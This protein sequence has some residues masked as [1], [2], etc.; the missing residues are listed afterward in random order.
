VGRSL[1][2][3][4]S[5]IPAAIGESAPASVVD[6]STA[7]RTGIEP[8]LS[9]SVA[10]TEAD[11]ARRGARPPVPVS[12]PI[13]D[14]EP[15]TKREARSPVAL[16]RESYA[17]RVDAPARVAR[18]S[19]GGAGRSGYSPFVRSRRS[20][21]RAHLVVLTAAVVVVLLLAVVGVAFLLG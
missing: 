20:P 5:A 17:P 14:G 19:T 8:R 7:P 12:V 10:D 18:V 11:S 2:E 6:T 16:Q 4:A 1:P 15:P 13:P 3:D 21:R 9:A